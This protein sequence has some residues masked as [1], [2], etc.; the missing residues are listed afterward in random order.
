M[1]KTSPSSSFLSTSNDCFPEEEEETSEGRKDGWMD[2]LMGPE[3]T[4]S[5]LVVFIFFIA[6]CHNII[7]TKKGLSEM[8]N[9][10]FLDTIG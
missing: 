7:E 10:P 6:D 8:N 2:G 5:L 4:A 9:R 3:R 1:M